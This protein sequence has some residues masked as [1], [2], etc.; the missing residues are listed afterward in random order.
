MAEIIRGRDCIVFFKGDSSTVTVSQA[1]VTSGWPGGQGVQW[2]DAAVDDRVVT[3]S[4]GL[5]GGF[6]I[7]GSNETGDRFTGASDQQKTYRYATMLAG[8]NLIS[9]S[10]YEKYTYASRLAGGPFV[11][12]AYKTQDILY[13]SLR[14][15]WTNENELTLSGS[16]LAP[17][18]FTGFVAQAPKALNNFFMGIQTSM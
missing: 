2:V 5:Y 6:L 9:T 4:G 13:L 1:M 11:P 18:F 17:A 8:G 15:L 16:P 7:W 12:I 10:S 3:Y 14:G